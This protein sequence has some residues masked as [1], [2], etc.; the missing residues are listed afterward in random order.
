[1]SRACFEK[2]SS[3]GND[4]GVV[5]DADSSSGRNGKRSS[6]KLLVQSIAS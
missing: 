5:A 3:K 1:M 4:V 2:V 6:G